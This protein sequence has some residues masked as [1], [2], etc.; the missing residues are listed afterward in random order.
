MPWRIAFGGGGLSGLHADLGGLRIEAFGVAGAASDVELTLPELSG[1]VSVRFDGDVSNVA[2]R[3][4]E[5][6]PAGVRVGGGRANWRSTTSASAPWAARPA[7]RAPTT[8][9]P[10]TATR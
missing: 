9:A 2:I 1:T 7:W 3:R 8:P 5:G 4:P 10:L 6:V